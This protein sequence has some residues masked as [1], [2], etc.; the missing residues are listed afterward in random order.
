MSHIHTGK[1]LFK[2]HKYEGCSVKYIENEG[3]FKPLKI[4]TGTGIGGSSTIPEE[5]WK[6][7]QVEVKNCI[8]L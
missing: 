8:Q 2:E 6:Q 4:L 5:L 7:Q 1:W 3:D